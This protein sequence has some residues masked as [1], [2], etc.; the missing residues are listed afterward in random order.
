MSAHSKMSVWSDGICTNI[1]T[2]SCTNTL[3]NNGKSPTSLWKQPEV[4]PLKDWYRGSFCVILKPQMG[5]VAHPVKIY[6]V[7]NICTN[8]CTK[9]YLPFDETHRIWW[10][11]KISAVQPSLHDAHEQLVVPALCKGS[12]LYL[13]SRLYLQRIM[14]IIIVIIITIKNIIAIIRLCTVHDA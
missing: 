14:I 4:S 9:K 3:A 13:I 1:Y 10:H 11:L 7:A 12:S 2:N 6:I 8:I 5:S